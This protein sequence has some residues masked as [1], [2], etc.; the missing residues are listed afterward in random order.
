RMQLDGPGEVLGVEGENIV[1]WKVVPDE[2]S[3]QLVI[4][5]ARPIEGEGVINVRSQSALGSMPVTAESLRLIP[6]GSVRHSG[7]VR[8]VNSGAVRLEVTGL[9]GLLQLEPDLFGGEAIGGGVRQVFVYRFPSAG[10]RFQVIASQIQPEVGV[11]QI[12]T[13]ELDETDRVIRADLELDIRDAPLRDWSLRIPWDFAVVSVTGDGVADYV[14]E[15]EASENTRALKILFASAVEGRQLLRLHLEKNRAAGAGAWELPPLVFPDASSVRGH[16]GAISVPGYRLIPDEVDQLVEVPLSYF[17]RQVAGLQQAWRIKEPEWTASLTIEALGQSVEADVFHLYSLKEGVVHGSVLINFFVVGAPSTEWKIEVPESVGNIDVVG[18]DVR[19]DWRRVGNEIT[20]SLHQPVLGAATLLITFDQPMSARGGT[21]APG[22]I[23]PLGVQG[24]RGYVQVVSPLQVKY[25]VRESDA[26]LLRLDPLELPTEYRLL[27]SAPSLAVYQYTARPFSLEMDVQWYERT[28]TVD[29]VVDFGQLT[30]VISRD[31]QVVTNARYFVKTRGRKALRMVLP[32]NV[33]LWEARVD[34]AIVNARTDGEQTLIPL[35]A[36]LNPN[37]SVEVALRLGQESGRASRYVKLT[38]PLLLVPTVINEWTLRG[39]PDRVLVPSGGNADLT[40]PAFTN[41]GFEWLVRRGF[42]RLGILLG[43]TLVGGLMLRA[44]SGW[45]LPAGIVVCGIAVLAALFLMAESSLT[46]RTNTGEISYAASV[47][48]AGEAMTVRVANLEVGQA[49]VSWPGV[50]AGMV[51]L[52]LIVLAVIPPGRRL[53]HPRILAVFGTIFFAGGLLAQGGGAT[54][55]FGA[56]AA[57][58]SFMVLLALIRWWRSRSDP[59]PTGAGG[60]NIA[61]SVGLA[62]GFL[63]VLAGSPAE[64]SAAGQP[65]PSS[66]LSDES[67]AAESMD[68]NWE[69][70]D[71][72]LFAEIDLTVRGVAGDSFLLLRAPAVLTGFDGDGLRVGKIG[73][74]DEVAYYVALEKE[75]TVAAKVRFEMALADGARR[76]LVPT[77]PAAIQRIRIDLDQ[78]GWEFASDWA[79]QVKSSGDDVPDH[80]RA[81]LTLAPGLNQEIRFE[82]RRRDTAMEETQFFTE[83]ANL[84]LPGPGVVNGVTGI[85]VRPAQG[86]VSELSIRVADGFTVGDVRGGPVGEW[87]FDPE[88][89]V[90]MVAIEPQQTKAFR[91]VVETQMTTDALPV[92]VVL[93]PLRVLD[94]AGEVGM[95]ALAFGGDAQPEGVQSTGLSP[96]NVEDFDRSLVSQTRDGKPVA[97]LQNVWRYGQSGGRLELTVAPVAPEVRVAGRQVFSLGD[98]RL[99]MAAEFEVSIMRVGLF[100]LSF[101]LPEGLEVEALSGPALSHWTEGEEGGTRLV[102]LHLVGQ[103]MG[104]Q[105]FSLTLAGAAPRARDSWSIPRL[106]M[107]EATRQTGELLIVPGKGIRLRAV[108]RKGVTQLDPRSVG[109][110]QPGTLAFRLLQKHWALGVGVEVLDPWVTVRSLQEVT[111]REGQ[112]RTR[113]SSVFR[114]ENAAVRQLTVRLSGLSEDQIRTVRGSGSAVSDFVAVRDEPDLWEIRFQRGIVGETDVQIEYQGQVA[115]EQ[116][117]SV[118]TTP[119]FQE[120]RQTVQFV[121]VRGSG[122]LELVAN[123]HPRGWK[124]VDWSG[125]PIGLQNR[126]DRS[127]PA[128]CYRVAEPESGLEVTVSR[129]DVADALKLRV[130]EAVLSTVFSPA[131]SFLTAVHLRMD[132]LEKSTLQVRLPEGAQLFNTVVNGETVSAVKEGAGHLFYVSPISESD[133]SAI[134]RFVYS[135]TAKQSGGIGLQGPGLSTPLE[136]V[137]WRVVLP[138]GYELDDYDGGLRLLGGRYVGRFGLEQYQLITKSVRSAEAKKGIALL[139]EAS[140]LLQRGKQQEAGEVLQRAS[141]AQG[142]DEASNEDARVQLRA[143]KT[144]QAVLGLNTRRQR[145]YLHNRLDTARNEQLE[146]AATLNPF[147]QGRLD[148]DPRQVDQLLMGNTVEENA[149]LRGIATR[150]VDLQL[151]DDPTPA[152]IE[153]TL[154]E[155]GQVL[156]FSRSLQVDGNAPL[157]LFLEIE[158]TDRTSMVALLAIII[159]VGLVVFLLIPQRRAE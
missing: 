52:A 68:Q 147:M 86:R 94:A 85:T 14:V 11:S 61:A 45:R 158:R 21:I 116:N 9:E 19:R 102:T 47:V 113:I 151:A 12:V 42:G 149:A 93:E 63:W 125:V 20:I 2:Q 72:R 103:T 129:H 79:V 117:L 35:S 32:G 50:V 22:E 58:V 150:L 138:Q 53:G 110:T 142:L 39:D 99:V 83:A 48:P 62:I 108:E 57:A 90:L 4:Q 132:V 29:Q 148:F 153:V 55:F 78:G 10:Y 28:E 54:A 81:T 38:A 122:R 76:I 111:M 123:D 119:D 97:V 101:E 139:E 34:G 131:G 1:G 87:R 74:R 106:S 98:D 27:T 135:L 156:T 95:I 82:A 114:V 80:S 16:V 6:V 56:I 146:Q 107:R 66:V 17:P 73:D 75:G 31:G 118:V 104:E 71:D 154:P 141:N 41:R 126:T 30:S 59:D 36:R 120:A 88:E 96:V 109:G 89:K 152:A 64:S 37:D 46:R 91:F 159:G 13:Y 84:Y 77:G 49:L 130:T 44:R 145:L 134:V 51:G 143:L 8:V 100:N 40:T 67:K 155:R 121:A 43:L 23:R 7:M 33:R 3:R 144:Q 140:S 5:F 127:V 115:R 124:R 137:S 128:L 133:P 70:R 24:E 136:N 157:D 112:T 18:Q 69:I 15:S 26:G 65:V 92:G 105:T 60:I 25:E